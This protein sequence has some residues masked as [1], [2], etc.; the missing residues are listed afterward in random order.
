MVFFKSL[1]IALLLGFA[2]YGFVRYLESHSIFFPSH[3]R[4]D[5]PLAMD[6]QPEDV[7]LKTDDNVQLHG[8]F[9]DQQA[10]LTI[11]FFHGNAGNVTHRFEK[12]KLMSDIGFNI[13][14]I[15]YRG[16]GQSRGK[17]SEKGLYR[18]A[19]AAYQYLVH[20]RGVDPNR[21]VAFGES[22]GGAVAI[23]LAM[24]HSLGGLV[25]EETFTSVHDMVRAIYPMIPPFLV[26]TKFDAHAKISQVRC[27]KLIMHSINDEIVPFRLGRKLYEAASEPK[28]FVQLQGPHNSAFWDS[29][30]IWMG[31]LEQ[32]RSL[33]L[34]ED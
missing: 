19:E 24:R 33:V 5:T 14:I 13:L 30:D 17:P 2:F 29:N 8:W 26:Q 4:Y 11:L 31:A 6:I 7:W 28:Q 32:F 18:D 3:E 1:T 21:I 16:Y 10:P 27:P 23:D 25:T 12:I 20:E 9:V 22:L 34:R 15:D